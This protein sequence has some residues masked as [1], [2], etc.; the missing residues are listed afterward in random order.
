MPKVRAPVG[1]GR[2]RIG[3]S[4]NIQTWTVCRLR[5]ELQTKFQVSPGSWVK[6][7]GL[8]AMLRKAR[9]DT[10]DPAPRLDPLGRSTTAGNG[11][12][13]SAHPQPGLQ[14]IAVPGTSR[15]EPAETAEAELCPPQRQDYAT[16]EAKIDLLSAT[17]AQIVSHGG[18]TSATGTATPAQLGPAN[19]VTS[20]FPFAPPLPGTSGTTRP[21][22]PVEGSAPRVT[23]HAFPGSSHYVTGIPPTPWPMPG[24]PQAP[25]NAAHA[26]PEGLPQPGAGQ[27]RSWDQNNSAQPPVSVLGSAPQG[28]LRFGG[29]SQQYAPPAPSLH[30]TGRPCSLFAG[31]RANACQL[32][33][34]LN[35]LTPF[36]PQHSGKKL[37]QPSQQHRDSS[38]QNSR[39]L[40]NFGSTDRRG[41]PRVSYGNREICNNFNS[42]QGCTQ[43]DCRNAHVCLKCQG[44][45]SAL[46]CTGAAE[47]KHIPVHTKWQ[48]DYLDVG[49]HVLDL[50]SLPNY[51]SPVINVQALDEE[52]KS[53]PERDFVNDLITGC[54]SGFFPGINNPPSETFECRNLLSARKDPETTSQLLQSELNKG[55]LIGPFNHPPFPK[56]RVNPIGLAERKFSHKK[57]LIVDMSAPHDNADT[58]SLNSLIN[59]EE[60]SLSYVK[61]DDA[62]AIIKQLGANSWLCKTDMTDAF[63]QLPLHPSVWHLHG[64]KW[65]EKYY[66]YTRLVFGCRSSPKIFDKLSSAIA[67]I[68]QNQYGLKFTLHLLDDF[69]SIIQ[70]QGLPHQA[71][72]SLLSIFTKLNLPYSLPKTVGPALALEYLGIV[73][74]SSVMET[75]LPADKLGRLTDM[76]DNF[77]SKSKCQKRELLS[78]LGH[79]NFAAR[80]VAPGRPFMFRLFRAAFSVDHL[81][82]RVSLNHECK[83]DLRMWAHLLKHWNGI[84][85]F[86]DDEPTDAGCF[87][88]FTDASGIGY[89]G[90]YQ[91]K[92]FFGAWSQ[93]TNIP[94]ITSTS[95]AFKELYPIVV[96][97]LL[98]GH[99]WG[100]K[101]L[102]FYSD[103]SAV[104]HVLNKKY[105]TSPDIMRL[106]RRL[107]LQAAWCN[108]TF[109]GTHIR[110]KSNILSD[111]LS[112]LQV[113]KFRQLAPPGT[114]TLPCQPPY[115]VMFD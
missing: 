22:V 106:L 31:Q 107:V 63:K 80:V 1:P 43:I 26:F 48:G 112:R 67:W 73:L 72:Q 114:E 113:G 98:W 6:K 40:A 62:I 17:V 12:R 96:A 45:H 30:T 102:A 46:L 20:G 21:A 28:N 27:S 91:G 56:F 110:G 86:L 52:L 66:F 109:I 69:L 19:D 44:T 75:R 3:S 39:P 64:I 38:R 101:R 49:G 50:R 65:Q 74:D 10:L 92:W 88:L 16:L 61:I 111:A 97:T 57:R 78:I 99:Q 79:L 29:A 59:K 13:K 76:V 34:S 83:A 108:F 77:L 9:R 35:H 90:F 115:E 81:Y 14:T 15:D 24:L 60:F 82:K 25:P 18:V 93:I 8:M 105:S 32:C 104:V 68:A 33:R 100:R 41:R 84:S 58:P 5:R 7:S 87:G 89:G 23:A 71:M 70:P 42:S 37:N 103:N 53:H 11:R 4:S 95:I 2:P 54:S 47:G 55:F 85:L 51:T 36:C 94:N